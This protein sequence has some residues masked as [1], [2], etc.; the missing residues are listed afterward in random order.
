MAT[1]RPPGFSAAIAGIVLIAFNGSVVLK[2]NPLGDLLSIAAALVWAFYSVLIRKISAQPVSMLAVTRQVVF[3]GLLFV[4]PVLPF[5]GIQLGLER[6]L[7]L[8]NLLNLIFLGVGSS[9]LSYITWNSAVRLL[10]P[11]KTS[12]YIYLVPVV[13][14][15][16]SVLALHEPFTLVAG[17]GMALILVGMALSEREKK[18]AA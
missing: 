4:L 12:V 2:L 16:V 6:L 13:T 11:V 18:A 7:A 5:F 9:A 1:R 15:A 3:Y 17:V 10:G 8:P 14:I